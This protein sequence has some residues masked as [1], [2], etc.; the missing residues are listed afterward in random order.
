MIICRFSGDDLRF[1]AGELSVQLLCDRFSDFTLHRKNV[2]QFAIKGI[3]PKMR[4][5]RC[6]DQLHV[7]AH[8]VAALLHAAFQD[9]RYAEL[10]GDLGQILRR[11]FVMLRRGAR[12]H[13]QVRDLG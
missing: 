5:I 12:D 10:P 4:I 9:M 8:G 7:H 6:L 2:D 13:L 3:G 1:L 11:A